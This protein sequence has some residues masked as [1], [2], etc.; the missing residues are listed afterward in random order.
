MP[1]PFVIG[2]T[3]RIACGK[4]SVMRILADLGASTFDADTVYHQLIAPMSPLWHALRHRFGD[5][6][7]ADDDHI[8][9]SALASIV[10][11]DP[12]SLADLDEMTH[13]AVTSELRRLVSLM[14]AG[15]V[16]VDAV[17]LV[18]S[19]FD[20]DCD[21]VWVVT[22][23]RTQQID[24]LVA[25]NNLSVAAAALRVDAQPG[26]DQVIAR[27]DLVIDNSGDPGQTSATVHRAW[28]ELF[29]DL[30]HAA[31]HGTMDHDRTR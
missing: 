28:T 2:V 11:A 8:D 13:P 16:A 27:A 15:V 20:R 19:G 6:I 10:F 31:T 21:R 1:G 5:D 30:A 26:F 23:G 17:K 25:R 14:D 22:C 24:R 12:K 3:G 9:R 4:T 29:P 7:L 18:E